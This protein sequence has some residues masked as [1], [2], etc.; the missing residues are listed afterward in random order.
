MGNIKET[1][2]VFGK[3]GLKSNYFIQLHLS[4][5]L[6]HSKEF[7]KNLKEY[8]EKTKLT[9]PLNFKV[10]CVEQKT[11]YKTFFEKMVGAKMVISTSD[12]KQGRTSP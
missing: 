2:W 6:T 9:F 11:Q 1:G 5:S 8:F 12:L 3:A 4:G 10:K 7:A